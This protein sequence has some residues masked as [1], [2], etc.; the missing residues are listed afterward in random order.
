MAAAGLSERVDR[1][2]TAI[3]DKFCA[4]LCRAFSNVRKRMVQEY[5]DRGLG[6]S[7]ASVARRRTATNGLFGAFRRPVSVANF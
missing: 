5:S 7:L 4:S 6:E 2:E 3:P 1:N